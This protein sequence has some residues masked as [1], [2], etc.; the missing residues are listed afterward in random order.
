MPVELLKSLISTPSLSRDEAETATL[1][2]E[3]LKERG[4]EVE[5]RE[6]NIIA[7]SKFFD[8]ARATL[9]LNSHHDTVKPAASY[10]RDPFSPTIEGDRLYGLGSNDAGASV[11]GLMHT[12]HHFYEV[13]LPFNL[14]LA[15]TAEEEVMGEKGIRMLIDEW[16][17]VDMAIV[18]EPTQMQ[19]GVGERGLVVLD[20]VAKGRSGHA[21]RD[22]GENALYKAIEDIHALR[23]FRFESCSELLG[24]IRMTATMIEAGTQHNVIPDECRWVV[25]IRTTDVYTNE[26]VVEILSEEFKSEIKPRSTRVRASA[27]DK[28]HPL[29]IV[30]QQIGRELYISPTTSDMALMPFPSIK[31][32]IGDST[33]SHTA[34]EYVLLS[35]LEEGIKIYREYI[36]KL[37]AYYEAME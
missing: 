35:D 5:R 20:C 1:I 37:A 26:Q 24:D 21:A 11:V 10:T 12:F 15:I 36:E 18:G 28:N 22:E 8:P 9:L 29:S 13:E 32:G 23:N 17:D 31:M 14:I 33:R 3:W 7:R 27:L 19:G 2:E 6:N 16:E 34:D 25:D 30:A 4:V